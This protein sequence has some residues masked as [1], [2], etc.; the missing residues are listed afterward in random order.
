MGRKRKSISDEQKKDLEETLKH[1]KN[2]KRD[3]KQ[4][5]DDSMHGPIKLL[6][7]KDKEMLL[8]QRHLYP[9]KAKLARDR[10]SWRCVFYST[11][12]KDAGGKS[13]LSCGVLVCL[14]AQNV[15]LFCCLHILI[16]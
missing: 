5:A 12:K 7:S 2:D 13:D 9:F 11:V 8:Y 1:F 3:T 14:N 15:L 10:T 4:L 6:T 16:S